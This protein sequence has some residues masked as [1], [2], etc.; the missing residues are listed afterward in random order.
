VSSWIFR[1]WEAH[2]DEAGVVYDLSHVHPIQYTLGLDETPK[3]PAR[4]VPIH[5]G[6]SSHTFTQSCDEA[7]CH[8]RY[9][10]PNDPRR[11]CPD[12]YALS[13]RLPEIVTN[14]KGRNC[15]LNQSRVSN[16]L[17]ADI[18]GVPQ[19]CEYWVF[20]HL[21]GAG[22]DR[23]A[24]TTV[25]MRVDSAYVGRVANPPYGAKPRKYSFNALVGMVLQGTK[26]AR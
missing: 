12:R 9:S 26:P 14:L 18:G 1:Y 23:S 17:V 3:Y 11:F 13:R 21:V 22:R 25:L 4:D 16:Y 8:N 19:G 6:F 10:P 15:F 20:F 2:T 24:P 7:D 5:V